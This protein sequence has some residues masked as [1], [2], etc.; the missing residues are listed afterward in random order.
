[1]AGGG[2]REQAWWVGLQRMTTS[3][4]NAVR[5][6]QVLQTYD[7]ED[8]LPEVSVPT[9]VLHCEGDTAVPFEEGQRMASRILGARFVSLPGRNHILIDG[10]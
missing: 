3:P 8:L 4:N 5:I 2:P 1:M 7:V 9:L 6:R 10:Q